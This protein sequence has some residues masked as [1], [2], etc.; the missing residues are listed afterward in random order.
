MLQESQDQPPLAAD[1]TPAALDDLDRNLVALVN[2]LAVKCARIFAQA[3]GTTA[4][5][6]DVRTPRTRPRSSSLSTSGVD[7]LPAVLVRD[8]LVGSSSNEPVG[9]LAM[10]YVDRNKG[11]CGLFRARP[12]FILP[13]PYAAGDS[14]LIAD[15]VSGA[16]R[17]PA[18]TS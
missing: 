6:A 9:S 13:W 14:G 17:P 1:S 12:P 2:E 15:L 8:R 16:F 11:L 7:R 18:G 10:A 5:E 4:R 3:A